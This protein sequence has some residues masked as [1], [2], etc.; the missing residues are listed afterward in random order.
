[1]C[2]F[3]KKMTVEKIKSY[4]VENNYVG[5]FTDCDGARHLH[6]HSVTYFILECPCGAITFESQTSKCW[7]GWRGSLLTEDSI[8]LIA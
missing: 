8:D 3:C 1:M 4:Q 7:C 2:R 6:D 5:D